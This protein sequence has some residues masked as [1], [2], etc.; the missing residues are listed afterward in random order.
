VVGAQHLRDV[1]EAQPLLGLTEEFTAALSGF[2]QAASS[3][4]ATV[5]DSLSL[6][7]RYSWPRWL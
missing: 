4:R 1:L 5:S 3:R 7:S 6:D 2:S